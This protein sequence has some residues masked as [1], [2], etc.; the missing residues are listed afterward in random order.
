VTNLTATFTAPTYDPATN[1][2]HQTLTWLGDDGLS[3]GSMEFVA[4]R[5]DMLPQPGPSGP[6]S[7]GGGGSGTAGPILMYAFGAVLAGMH[8]VATATARPSGLPLGPFVG[9]T[10]SGALGAGPHLSAGDAGLALAAA[11]FPGGEVGGGADRDGPPPP[12]RAVKLP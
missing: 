10:A 12:G 8:G 1:R 9:R 6:P 7:P 3:H 5:A 2:F 11:G 4:P